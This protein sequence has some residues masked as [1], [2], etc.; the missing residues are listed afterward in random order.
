LAE[1]E[2]MLVES[3]IGRPEDVE[4]AKA[5]S[6]GLGLFVRSLVGLDREQSL[7]RRCLFERELGIGDR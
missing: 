2:R 3:G 6:H 5:E 7:R 4:K 1:L